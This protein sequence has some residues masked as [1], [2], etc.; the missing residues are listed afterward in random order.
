VGHGQNE[1]ARDDDGDGIREVHPNPS[2]GL[3]TPARH[4]LRPF[5]GVH[6]NYLHHSLAR[7]EHTIHLNRLSP[8]FIARRVTQHRSVT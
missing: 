6:Q 5:R 8:Q 4:F 7:C 2:E 1:W 3:W